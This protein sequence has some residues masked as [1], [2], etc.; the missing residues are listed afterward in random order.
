MLSEPTSSTPSFCDVI[1]ELTAPQRTGVCIVWTGLRV[2][3]ATNSVDKIVQLLKLQRSIVNV[4]LIFLSVWHP[5][6]SGD[7]K[8]STVG[9]RIRNI[10]IPNPFENGTF[11][12]LVFERSVLERSVF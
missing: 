6:Y 8:S 10:Q 4:L 2:A 9:A 3:G 5:V 7:L 12:S 11:Q 1:N